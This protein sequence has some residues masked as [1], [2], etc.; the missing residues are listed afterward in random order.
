MTNCSVDRAQ[1]EGYVMLDEAPSPIEYPVLAKTTAAKHPITDKEDALFEEWVAARYPFATDGCADPGVFEQ[2]RHR[3]VFV[4]KERNGGSTSE[5]QRKDALA[6]PQVDLSERLAELHADVERET[7]DGWWTGMAQWAEALLATDPVD[8]P[9]I[10]RRFANAVPDGSPPQSMTN[11][12][13]DVWIRNKNKE[14]LGKCAC[15]QLKK[16][17]GGPKLNKDNFGVI[18]SEDRHF[19]LH[20]FAIYSPHFIVSCGSGDNWNIFLNTLF[21]KSEVKQTH[22]GIQYFL[23]SSPDHGLCKTAVVNFGHPS[24]R[25]NNSLWGAL[26]FGLREALDEIKS[27]CQGLGASPT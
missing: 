4:L 25:V 9:T 23:A 17:P 11:E 14:A 1:Y 22:N 10:E 16:A 18:V 12:E 7:F 21:P 5:M 27:S 6:A 20:Q 15:V 26:T 8:W 24:M 13:K 2:S 19:I 3:I